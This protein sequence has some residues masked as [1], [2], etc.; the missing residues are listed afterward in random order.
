M[1]RS[2]IFRLRVFFCT[3][4][5]LRTSFVLREKKGSRQNAPQPWSSSLCSS[6]QGYV[7]F[8]ATPFSIKLLI[9]IIVKVLFSALNVYC[10]LLSFWEKFGCFGYLLNSINQKSCFDCEQSRLFEDLWYIFIDI[11]PSSG[12]HYGLN[13]WDSSA[14][15]LERKLFS[16]NM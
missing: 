11:E 15:V 8:L 12:W 14:W 9:Q 1:L 4:C 7:S 5:V 16:Y 3:G 6:S 13:F 10:E 2:F